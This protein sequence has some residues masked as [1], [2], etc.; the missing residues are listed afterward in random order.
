MKLKDFFYNA[1]IILPVFNKI[2]SSVKFIIT[3]NKTS[4]ELL[5]ARQEI[6]DNVKYLKQVVDE[7]NNFHHLNKD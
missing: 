2:Y 4:E 5:N 7:I 6:I 3:F 1:T